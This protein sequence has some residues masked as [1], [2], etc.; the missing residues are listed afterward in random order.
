MD[1]E[2]VV[3]SRQVNPWKRKKEE[4]QIGCC[5]AFLFVICVWRKKLEGSR[6]RHVLGA[7]CSSWCIHSFSTTFFSSSRENCIWPKKGNHLRIL[8]FSRFFHLFPPPS[9]V[10][11][12]R[13]PFI[14]ISACISHEPFLLK[15]RFSQLI[16]QEK[17]CYSRNWKEQSWHPTKVGIWQRGVLRKS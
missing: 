4:M 5:S 6:P 13:S 3:P 16:N 9:G 11:L 8:G 7:F 10:L 1:V 14:Q 15:H 2:L 12:W 17:W